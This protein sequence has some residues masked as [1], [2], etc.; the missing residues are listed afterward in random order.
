MQN[1]SV[2]TQASGP[3]EHALTALNN[4]KNTPAHDPLAPNPVHDD[5]AAAGTANH[6]V[7]LGNH[8][9]S[10]TN[11]GSEY[12][13]STDENMDLGVSATQLAQLLQSESAGFTF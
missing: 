12:G 6:G 4:N 7:T 5:S 9:E 3:T 8:L 13:G 1:N 10:F 11:E 2:P